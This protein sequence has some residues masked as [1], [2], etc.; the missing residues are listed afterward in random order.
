MTLESKIVS[1]MLVACETIVRKKY[2]PIVRKQYPRY[3]H[4][5]CFVKGHG[6][7]TYHRRKDSYSDYKRHVIT[8]GVKMV[9]LKVS[10]KQ[11]AASCLTGSEI[12]NMHFLG[13]ELTLK[14]VLIHTIVH[15][16]AHYL[17]VIAGDRHRRSVHNDAFY[18]IVRRL[19][20]EGLGEALITF[21]DTDPVLK[22]LCFATNNGD[23]DAQASTEIFSR[24]NIDVGNVVVFTGR[25]RGKGTL[26]LQGTVTRI[27]TKSVSLDVT[28][29]FDKRE[30][31]N[32]RIP[33]HLITEIQK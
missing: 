9:A 5:L 6:V 1:A 13:G 2:E 10:S 21:F 4:T 20:D 14:N 12:L 31:V 8:F 19:Y 11:R 22:E 15:E 30:T 25:I 7:K 26:S 33:Y 23:L 3:A 27:N 28:N 32:Y 16:F 24:H 29:P 17:Q 18:S